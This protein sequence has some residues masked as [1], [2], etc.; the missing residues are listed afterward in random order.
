VDHLALE[1]RLVD[2]IVV[3]EAERAH[4]GGREVERRRRSEPARA[5]EQHLRMEQLELALDP[6]LWKEGVARVALALLLGH[7]LGRNDGEAELLPG[8]DAAGDVGDVLVARLL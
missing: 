4:S 2:E 5:E 1:V 6:D 3:H 8:L 7:A